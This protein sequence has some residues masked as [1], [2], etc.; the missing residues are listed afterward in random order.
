[1]N[2]G[3][4]PLRDEPLF[5]AGLDEFRAAR[6]FEAHEEWE[7]LWMTRAGDEKL[8]LQALIQL[9][10]A[11]VHLTRGNAGPGIRLLSLAG[12][13]LVRFGDDYAGVRVDFL[14]RGI[15]TA[16]EQLRAGTV[17]A[18]RCGRRHPRPRPRAQPSSPSK[19]L[20][21]LRSSPAATPPPAP[22]PP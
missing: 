9:A 6:F 22:R 17:T 20:F 14:G 13:K 10:A 15:V 1:V 18:T 16:Q 4:F 12:E 8:F 11:C 19:E 2:A 3:T 21:P 7:R 5:R